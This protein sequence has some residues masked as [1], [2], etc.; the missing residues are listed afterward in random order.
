MADL[1]WAAKKARSLLSTNGSENKS[2]LKERKASTEEV[3]KK[4]M[5]PQ[6]FGLSFTIIINNREAHDPRVSQD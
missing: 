5:L 2:T 6:K 4:S 3:L 1:T